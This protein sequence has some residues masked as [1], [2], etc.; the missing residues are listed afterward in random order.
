MG[1]SLDLRIHC[2]LSPPSFLLS[3]SLASTIL[4]F[5]T[6]CQGSQPSG[7][8]RDPTPFVSDEIPPAPRSPNALEQS[9]YH[10]VNQ[11]RQSRNLPPL[12]LSDYLNQQARLQNEQMASQNR[13]LGNDDFEDR[14]TAIAN[15]L[16]FQNVAVNLAKFQSKG[17][18]AQTILKN[19]LKKPQERQNL[20]GKFDLTGIAIDQKAQNTVFVSQIFLE[21]QSL[22]A[23]PPSPKPS[24]SPPANQRKPAQTHQLLADDPLISALEIGAFQQVNQYRLSQGLAPLR[25]DPRISQVARKH[26]QAM[27]AKKAPFS[28]AGFDQRAKAL[29][30]FLSWSGVGENLAYI[31]GYPDV[32]ATAVKGWIQSPGHR[33]NMEGNFNLTG[34][35]VAKNAA[36]DYYFSQLFVL[37]P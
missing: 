27:A 37:E 33:K 10:Q 22:A 26:A 25:L 9:L 14:K 12:Q 24:S 20:E 3:L 19:W 17:D 1:N 4:L 6:G 35:G 28:H 16:N 2:V 8:S 15:V 21:I 11:Y 18:I 32:V 29:K 5:L 34:M 23:E 31:K 13:L 36:G 7:F 30:S